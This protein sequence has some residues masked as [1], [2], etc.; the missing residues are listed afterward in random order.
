MDFQKGFN[1]NTVDVADILHVDQNQF[2]A[3]GDGGLCGLHEK[4]DRIPGA[5]APGCLQH[6]T[7]LKCTALNIKHSGD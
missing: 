1:A 4:F 3:D 7:P 6:G 5:E 2:V